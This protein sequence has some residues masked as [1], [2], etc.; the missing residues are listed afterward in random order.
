MTRRPMGQFSG[1]SSPA[2]RPVRRH[3]IPLYDFVC[4]CGEVTEARRGVDVKSIP[5]PACGEKAVRD[6]P[7]N[8]GLHGLPTRA[9]ERKEYGK[10]ITQP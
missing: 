4:E 6:L 8:V 2:T 10:T 9:Q 3:A 1:L 7:R 5:C